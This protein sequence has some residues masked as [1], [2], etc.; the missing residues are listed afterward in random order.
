MS[1][2]KS[3]AKNSDK[4]TI[5]LN[6]KAR[7]DY[8][9]EDRFEAGMALE[10]WEVKSLRAGRARIAE[11]YVT[12]KNGE[13]WLLGSHI[14]RWDAFPPRGRR[15]AHGRAADG[16]WADRRFHESQLAC[17]FRLDADT[18]EIRTRLWKREAA[19]DLRPIHA[20]VESLLGP[21]ARNGS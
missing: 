2:K 18:D 10:G 19:E 3:A 4:P 17:W 13:V 5:A 14:E 12:L 7:H 21:P 8:A 1:K 9:L 16:F 15:V 20:L 6:R 11:A